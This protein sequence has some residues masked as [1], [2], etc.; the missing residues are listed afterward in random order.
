VVLVGLAW[1]S[2]IRIQSLLA[3]QAG[4]LAVVAT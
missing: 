3:E 1:L 4:P 2:A